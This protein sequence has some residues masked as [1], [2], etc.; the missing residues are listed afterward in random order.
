M[1]YWFVVF[2]LL[3]V[4]LLLK[5]DIYVVVDYLFVVVNG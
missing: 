2:E 5:G 3:E 1:F 4:L